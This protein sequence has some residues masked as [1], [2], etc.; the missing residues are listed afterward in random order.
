M[1]DIEK[2]HEWMLRMG[3]V[4]LSDWNRMSNAYEIIDENS[5]LS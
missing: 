2:F 1:S 4:H 5:K 3:N